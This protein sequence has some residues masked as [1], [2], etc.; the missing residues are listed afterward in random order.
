MRLEFSE[1]V[2]WFN[3]RHIKSFPISQSLTIYSYHTHHQTMS[4]ESLEEHREK[5]LSN[6]KHAWEYLKF[7]EKNSIHRPR[8]IVTLGQKVIK[9]NLVPSSSY[10]SNQIIHQI[11]SHEYFIKYKTIYTILCHVVSLFLL[12]F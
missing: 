11:I 4:A 10:V 12:F 3:C 9:Q 6:T 1:T 2:S 7:L 8:D 5:A